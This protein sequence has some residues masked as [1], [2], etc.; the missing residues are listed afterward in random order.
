[1]TNRPLTR[2]LVANRGEI[3]VRVIRGC[4]E[5]GLQAVAV[6]SE[7]DADALHVRMA[8]DAVCVGPAASASS[9]LVVDRILQAALDTGCD[10]VHPGYGFLSENAGFARRVAE[11]GLVWIGP[12]PA[13]IDAMGS[14]TEARRTLRAAHVPVVPGTVDPLHDMDEAR[15][16]A[17]D[18]GFPVMLKAAAGGGGKGMRR[19]DDP[20]DLEAALTAARS[21]ARKSFADDAVYVEKLVEHARHVEIQVLADAHGTVV[22]LFERDCSI[23]RR[24]QKVFEETPSPVLAPEVREAMGQVA[25]RAAA[26]VGYVGAG[27]CEFL[28]ASNHTD[29][30]F[31]E[32][33]TR[34]QVEHPITEMVTGIDLVRAQLRVAAGE[35]LWFAQGDLTQTGHAVEC[36]VYAEDPYA[37]F[38]PSPGP[39]DGYREPQGP[40]VRVDGGVYEGGEVPI[41]YDPMVAKLV[42][43]GTD[44]EEALSRAA[45]ALRDYKVVGIPTSIPFFLALF[46]DP[47]FR[48]GRYH[49]GFLTP[50]WLAAHLATPEPGDD[51]PLI[52]AAI[53]RFERDRALAGAAPATTDASAWKRAFRWAQHH[54]RPA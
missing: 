32:M 54:R 18:I 25:C 30:Y 41:H 48:A 6:Y 15:R 7:A 2:V 44:R 12:P 13:A 37:G 4:H 24:N 31:L 52:A 39:L 8:D 22:H 51:L 5:E 1:M 26:A 20:A 35:P 27:T 46:D 19:V 36:R 10:A 21:E 33:N 28:L 43:W 49:T 14:K 17:A 23:Q 34:L 53:A 3:A 50:A 16:I 38:R 9:Y 45:R 29:F 11:A 40:F 42:V 47:D